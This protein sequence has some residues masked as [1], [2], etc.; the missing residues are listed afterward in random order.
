MNPTYTRLTP[1]EPSSF[2]KAYQEGYTA[3]ARLRP[4]YAPRNPHEDEESEDHLAWLD[5][6]IAGGLL[7]DYTNGVRSDGR[8]RV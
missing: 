4:L 7:T 6:A 2:P 3:T 1:P 5:G 8:E